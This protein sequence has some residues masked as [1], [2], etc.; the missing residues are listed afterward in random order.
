MVDNAVVEKLLK[1][2]IKR[3]NLKSWYI[4]WKWCDEKFAAEACSDRHYHVAAFTQIDSSRWRATMFLVNTDINWIEPGGK[5]EGVHHQH[6]EDTIVHELAHV[7]AS[8]VGEKVFKLTGLAHEFGLSKI[9]ESMVVK[10]VVEIEEGFVESIVELLM[11]K[12]S[13]RE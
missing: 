6:L 8:A 9:V 4:T 7:Y 10:S 5:C 2:W 13:T 12:E 1:K 11:G 3:L